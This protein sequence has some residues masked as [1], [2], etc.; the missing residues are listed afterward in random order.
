LI[1]DSRQGAKALQAKIK[2]KFK[3]EVSYK[4]LYAGK[5]LAHKQLFGDRDSSL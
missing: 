5:E 4:R 1:E 3:V 2:E